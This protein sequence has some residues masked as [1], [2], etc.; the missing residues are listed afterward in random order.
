MFWQGVFPKYMLNYETNN[1]TS[2]IYGKYILPP[3][4]LTHYCN[5][6]APDFISRWV[7]ATFRIGVENYISGS[8]NSISGMRI[9]AS[10]REFCDHRG[11]ATRQE[12][13]ELIQTRKL[14]AQTNAKLML[15]DHLSVW[16]WSPYRVHEKPSS[17]CQGT[18]ARNVSRH[19]FRINIWLSFVVGKLCIQISTSQ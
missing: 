2:Y 5:F 15:C 13:M 11:Y 8:A 1:N 3:T 10:R 9:T 19:I 16:Q 12:C 6:D 18:R 4:L 14:T 17:I 7:L